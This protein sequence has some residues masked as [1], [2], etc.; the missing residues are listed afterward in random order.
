MAK[1]QAIQVLTVSQNGKGLKSVA[2]NSA[3][4]EAET[5]TEAWDKALDKFNEGK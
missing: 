1:Y 3:V 5:L 4:I 2:T